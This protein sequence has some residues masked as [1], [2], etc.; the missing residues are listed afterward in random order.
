MT[1]SYVGRNG[2]KLTEQIFNEMRRLK[3][4]YGVVPM[5][6]GTRPGAAS[7]FELLN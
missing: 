2:T 6:V 5:C 3:Q 1:G 4:K 7:V